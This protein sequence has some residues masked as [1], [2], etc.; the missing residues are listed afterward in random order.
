MQNLHSAV[1]RSTCTIEN[2][3]NL[4]SLRVSQCENGFFVPGKTNLRSC[5]SAGFHEGCKNVGRRGGFEEGQQAS[6][7]GNLRRRTCGTTDTTGICSCVSN[8][9]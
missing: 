8:I 3:K 2:R 1:A 4:T 6:Y 5:E 7:F 9:D